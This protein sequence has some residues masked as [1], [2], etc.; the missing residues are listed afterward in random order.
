MT[1]EAIWQREVDRERSRL[2]RRNARL[3]E[4][5]AT[6]PAF[7]ERRNA[8]QRAYYASHPELRIY[9]RDWKRRADEAKWNAAHS[10]AL[11]ELACEGPRSAAGCTCVEVV[12]GWM[13]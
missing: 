2:D 12:L 13:G 4:R 11:H 9:Q 3:R 10:G 1:P 6:D 5:R 7:R 8:Y